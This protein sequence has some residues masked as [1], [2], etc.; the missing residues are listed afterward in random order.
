MDG[1]ELCRIIRKESDIPLVMLTVR[2]KDVTS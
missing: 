2:G 1:S